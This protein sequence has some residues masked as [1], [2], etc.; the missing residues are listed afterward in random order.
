MRYVALGDSIT[1][2]RDGVRVYFEWMQEAAGELTLGDMTNGSVGGW[3]TADLLAGLEAKCLQHRP[4]RVTVMLGTNDHAIDK[5]R[6]E[7]R[8]SL[9]DYAGNLDA[10]VRRIRDAGGGPLNGDGMP[11][12]ILMT[13]PYVCTYTN[14]MGTMTSQARLLSYCRIV[15]E[16]S[17]RLG[18]GW[19]DINAKTAAATKGDDSM[20]FDT[21]TADGDGVHLNSRGHRIVFEAIR[22]AFA[23]RTQTRQGGW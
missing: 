16:T 23:S 11:D 7:P 14:R 19:I 4:E 13:P 18:T 3:T 9:S 2:F 5:E 20:F 22:E 6:T 12:V 15:K 17:E 1:A 21:F 10:I 8:V